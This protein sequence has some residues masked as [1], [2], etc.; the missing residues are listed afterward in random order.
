[1]TVFESKNKKFVPRLSKRMRIALKWLLAPSNV[2]LVGGKKRSGKSHLLAWLAWY[3]ATQL[4][5][6]VLTNMVYKKKVGPPEQG[7]PHGKF[8]MEYPPNVHYCNSLLDVMIWT[9][10]I[11]TTTDK[12]ILIIMDEIQNFMSAYEWNSP[13]AK[14]FVIFLGIISKLKQAYI[15]ATPDI[16]KFPLGIRDP[17]A[18]VATALFYKDIEHTYDFNAKADTLYKAKELVF[19]EREGCAKDIWEIGICEW[20]MHEAQV[21][22]GGY[23]Y[24]HLVPGSRFELGTAGDYEFDFKDI[25]EA[26]EHRMAEEIPGK[27]VE[28]ANTMRTYRQ[29][30]SGGDPSNDEGEGDN[31]EGATSAIQ[32][33]RSMAR[34]EPGMPEVARKQLEREVILPYIATFTN[35]K[36]IEI[37]N[38]GFSYSN[39]S[40]YSQLKTVR[41]QIAAAELRAAREAQNQRQEVEDDNAVEEDGEESNSGEEPTNLPPEVAEAIV[42]AVGRAEQKTIAQVKRSRNSTPPP[43]LPPP[44]PPPQQSQHGDGADSF[45]RD[46]NDL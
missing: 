23:V 9:A 2:I 41:D 42:G 32:T 14:D 34:I 33:A 22:I 7:W 28:F 25:I 15:L 45:E 24:D 10:D 12:T 20:A 21:E 35:M 30:W 26:T 17:A 13:L 37:A 43:N 8:V 39:T 29:I 4:N 3:A 44:P 19:V 36:P 16:S 1:M 38:S 6:I 31:E 27:L 46:S 5:C 11:I 40:I 18:D